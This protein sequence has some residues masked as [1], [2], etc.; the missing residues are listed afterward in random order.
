MTQFLKR[1][2]SSRG[3]S[4]GF[5]LQDDEWR[6]GR[7]LPKINLLQQSRI[8]PA[9]RLTVA[10]LLVVLVLEAIFLAIVYGDLTTARDDV[11]IQRQVLA[12]LQQRED[13]LA[14]KV[15]TL[16]QTIDQ[17]QPTEQ[18]RNVV[19]DSYRELT[20]GRVAWGAYMSALFGT[21]VS[22]VRFETVSTEPTGGNAEVFGTATNAA[23][24][25]S[26]QSEIVKASDILELNSL[27]WEEE[28]ASLDFSASFTLKETSG[29]E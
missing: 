11:D 29:N 5:G 14:E 13:Q 10:G 22:G 23:V 4:A 8:R 15:Q 6:R 2:F 16:Y 7:G 19:E 20:E 28:E 27:R 24:M 9:S 26:F 12:G 1:Y 18:E 17:L 25:R 21:V 3:N